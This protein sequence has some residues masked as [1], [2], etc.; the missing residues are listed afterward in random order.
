MEIGPRV[1]GFWLSRTKS[2]YLECKC[3]NVIHE[4]EEGVKIDAQVIP[5]RG[6]LKYLGATIRGTRRLMMMSH[7]VFE[8][9]G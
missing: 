8:W 9:G 2:E 6:S 4:A 3:S 1:K 7:M 5:K